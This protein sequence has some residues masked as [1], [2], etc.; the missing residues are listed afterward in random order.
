[1]VLSYDKDTPQY[2]ALYAQNDLQLELD[3]PIGLFNGLSIR[4]LIDSGRKDDADNWLK[5]MEYNMYQQVHQQFQHVIATAD[6]NSIR[7]KLG[8]AP[9]PFVTGGENRT[10]TFEKLTTQNP[11]DQ[12][13]VKKEDIPYYEQLGFTPDNVNTFFS[14]D[15]VAFFKEKTEG[16]SENTIRKYRAS[17]T[18]LRMILERYELTNWENCD[19][20]FWTRVFLIDFIGLYET[21]TKTAIKD[22]ISTSKA[23]AKWLDQQKK[24]ASLAKIVVQVTKET[25]DEMMRSV[26]VFN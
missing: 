17:L 22:F 24:T 4:E 13:V 11:E 21:L 20:A 6:Y 23:L 8:L 12:H 26:E 18:D 14:D 1:M 3:K 25:E 16:K 10:S 19:Q 15:F 2:F 9:S 5:Q 7:K